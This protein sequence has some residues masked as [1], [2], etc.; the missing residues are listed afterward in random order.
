MTASVIAVIAA[1]SFTP[2][3]ASAA[4]DKDIKRLEK[5]ILR[6]QKLL[7]SQ[8]RRLR[9]LEKRGHAPR[10]LAG[11]NSVIPKHGASPLNAKELSVLRG[12]LATRAGIQILMPNG[13]IYTVPFVSVS[14][15]GLTA[16]VA[17]QAPVEV[18]GDPPPAKKTPQPKAPVEPKDEKKTTKEVAPKD[19]VAPKTG[20]PAPKA[21]TGESARPKSEKAPEQ[22]LLARSAILLRPGT[23]QVEP[24]VEYSRFSNSRVAISGVSIFEA[25]IIGLIRVDSLD[26]DI[27]SGQLKARL[28]ILKRLQADVSI[29]YIYRRDREV[30]GVGTPTA[31]ERTIS[32]RGIGDVEVGLTTQPVIGGD[33]I[34]DILV[35]ANLLIPTGESP[36]DIPTEIVTGT[37][38]SRLIRTP[39]GSGFY[40]AGATATFVW[41]SDPVVF[42]TGAGYQFIF[43]RTFDRFGKINPGNSLQ[44]FA[45]LNLAVSEKVSLSLSFVNQQT[46]STKA[47]GVKSPGTSFSDSRLTL[48]ASVAIAKKTNLLVSASI[49]LGE[50][51]PDFV[52]SVRVPMTFQLWR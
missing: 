33:G 27:V 34:P 8:E 28:G 41:T 25:I 50:Q 49:G 48:G 32:G 16:A 30:L 45:G 22:L 17:P 10:R 6:Q 51:S 47:N 4:T 52:F 19:P 24:G 29:P 39:T 40:S 3:S 12:G 13:K 7:E 1:A 23:F 11:M 44:F 14:T 46:F 26:R 42:F 2:G 36:F 18:P 43:Q 9:L 21:P 38:E 35:R 5:I 37:N 20:T 31:S 15:S